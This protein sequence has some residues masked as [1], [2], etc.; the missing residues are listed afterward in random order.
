[1]NDTP[2]DVQARF[3]ELL[4]QR[5]GSDRIS[6]MSEMFDLARASIVA[7]I[8]TR[9]PALTDAEL[10][11]QLFERLYGN[12]FDPATRAEIMTRWREE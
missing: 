4:R 5:S 2:A 6:M 12:D 9:C 11:A 10:R 1:M 3:D 7:D 8:Q